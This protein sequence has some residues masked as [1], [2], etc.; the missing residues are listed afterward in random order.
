MFTLIG[1][2]VATALNAQPILPLRTDPPGG[3]EPEDIPQFILI[4]FDDAVTP[5]HFENVGEISDHQNPDGSDIGFTFYISLD[6]TDYWLV[7]QLHAAGHEI[8]I[9]TITHTTSTTT[10]HTTWIKEIEGAR[11]AL[12]RYAGV[13]RNDIRGF[14]APYLAYNPAMF[15]AL[16]DLGFLYDCS[17]SEQAGMESN[18][19]S[20]AEYIRPYSL[21]N[22]LQQN[23]DTGIPTTEGLPNLI[24][25]PMWKLMDGPQALLMDPLLNAGRSKDEIVQMFKEN[26]DTLYLG[27]RVPMG[28]WLH[29]SWIMNADNVQALN[30]FLVWA[31]GKDDVWVVPVAS[32]VDWER[33]PLPSGH[34]DLPALLARNPYVPVPESETFTN[35]FSQGHFRSVGQSAHAYPHP[36]M[37]YLTLREEAPLSVTT[38]W[39]IAPL[40]W[41]ETQYVARLYLASPDQTVKNWTFSI[42]LGNNEKKY[43]W[44]EVG[45]EVFE[46]NG[47]LTMDSSR[48]WDPDLG[49]AEKLLATIS[50][51]GDPAQLGEA[52]GTTTRLGPEPPRLIGEALPDQLRLR[53]DRNAP[54]FHVQGRESLTSG[55]WEDLEI[56]YGVDETFITFDSPYSFFRIKAQP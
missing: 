56:L 41:S 17:V 45:G 20:P 42:P 25:V 13:P 40:D 11:E 37:L 7:H 6:Y 46:S 5:Q 34:P 21:N 22:G 4:T 53:W 49:P 8:A 27:N 35:V 23:G 31:M 50:F 33:N 12:H 26:F 14:R 39:E 51:E 9:H 1:W 16:H 47:I 29:P 18:S 19:P 2:S 3:L 54:I 38:R 28:I 10:D 30:E 52:T 32:M 15:Q 43:G 36:D 44:S 24:E 48:A 55:D